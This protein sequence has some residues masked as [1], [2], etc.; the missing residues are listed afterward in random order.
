MKKSENV[1]SPSDQRAARCW[2]CRRILAV[3]AEE[4]PLCLD[5][6]CPVKDGEETSGAHTE[7]IIGNIKESGLFNAVGDCK[8]KR[9]DLRLT[10]KAM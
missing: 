3:L 7:E 10:L 2:G 8:R 9:Q 4:R 5:F 6:L 1:V